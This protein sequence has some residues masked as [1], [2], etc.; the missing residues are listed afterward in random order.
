MT[1]QSDILKELKADNELL[2]QSL[3]DL[4]KD[5]VETQENWRKKE[6]ERAQSAR[7]SYIDNG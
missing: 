3:R 2:Q 7:L 4:K 5:F 6:S 1:Q